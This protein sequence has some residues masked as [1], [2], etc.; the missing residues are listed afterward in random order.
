VNRVEQV[1][2]IQ[3]K[4]G[5][6]LRAAAAF[7]KVAERFKSDVSLERDGTRANGKSI[8][9]LVTLA[10][11]LG[12]KVK[13]VAEGSDAVDAVGALAQLVEDRF[14]EGS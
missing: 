3:N 6:H 5:L 1:C 12:T 2:Q 13:I 10:A 8:I 9:A 7:V 4:L 14:G 11:S